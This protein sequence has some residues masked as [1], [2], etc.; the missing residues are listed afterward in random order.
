MNFV[1]TL[2]KRSELQPGVPAL[3]DRYFSR[4]RVL[5]YAALNRLADFLSF[6]LRKKKVL[7]G[8]RVLFGIGAS[9]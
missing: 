5:T 1:Q 8:D 7:P 3:I 2:R 6:E 9:Q 4:D